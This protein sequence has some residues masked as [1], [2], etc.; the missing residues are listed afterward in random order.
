MP[1]SRISM[2][3]KRCNFKHDRFPRDKRCWIT[4][5]V[6]NYGTDEDPHYF[7]QFHEHDEKQNKALKPY[8]TKLQSH[9]K[10]RKHSDEVYLKAL[11]TTW[12]EE[13]KDR[14][15]DY[16]TPFILPGILCSGRGFQNFEFFGRVNFDDSCFYDVEFKNTIFYTEA[17]FK[18]VKFKCGN[19]S[20]DFSESQFKAKADFSDA[21]FEAETSFKA[22]RFGGKN[23][24]FFSTHFKQKA[25]FE[26]A[27][28]E[29][30]TQFE[31]EPKFEDEANF[32][33]AKFYGY[34]EFRGVEYTKSP[35]FNE[36]EFKETLDISSCDYMDGVVFSRTQFDRLVRISNTCFNG[37]VSF[38]NAQFKDHLLVGEEDDLSR[39]GKSKDRDRN[40]NYCVYFSRG[41][42]FHG[43]NLNNLTF[44]KVFV[45]NDGNEYGLEL[46]NLYVNELARFIFCKM[47]LV[48][49]KNTSLNIA[50]FEDCVCKEI[51][52]ERIK[53]KKELVFDGGNYEKGNF[54][55]LDCSLI[56]FRKI[57]TMYK[58]NFLDAYLRETHF[59][60]CD[61]TDQTANDIYPKIAKHDEILKEGE[62]KKLSRL[63]E[64]YRQLF[65]IYENNA[66]YVQAGKFHYREMQIRKKSSLFENRYLDYFVYLLYELV[67]DFGENWKKILTILIASFVFMA[68]LIM[69]IESWYSDNELTFWVSLTIVTLGIIPSGL[70]RE[71]LLGANLTVISLWL[72]TLQGII[73]LILVSL[74]VMAIRRNYKR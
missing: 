74:F 17:S 64:I 1:L 12:N 25:D 49:L 23:T 24:Q 29:A 28:F 15:V 43:A 11:L 31:N 58:F 56:F 45:G 52:L 21:V 68:F 14:H 34:T 33:R 40:S 6:I 73:S 36:A 13:N 67:S 20:I 18:K 16:R 19:S 42:T 51:N 50:S 62:I 7:C 71:V 70:Q 59:S 72:I 37:V 3:K 57:R 48:T 41:V 27:V 26:D 53:V 22:A 8:N 10:E 44:N 30:H 55:G 39:D 46:N 35:N 63:A 66:N 32:R 60:S 61:W 54:E 38:H 2:E 69:G 65:Q 4:D 47:E 9:L 5:D